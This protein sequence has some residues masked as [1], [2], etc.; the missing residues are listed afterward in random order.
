MS[1]WAVGSVWQ[2]EFSVDWRQ[3]STC[4]ISGAG[5]DLSRR[6][7]MCRDR[8]GEWGGCVPLPSR[9]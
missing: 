3:G 2:M 7:R 4:R 8:C 1:T 5:S 6:R 9:L